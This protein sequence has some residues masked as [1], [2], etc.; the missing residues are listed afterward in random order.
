MLGARLLPAGIFG[1]ASAE[2]EA[3]ARPYAVQQLLPQRRLLAVGRQLERVEARGGGG[4]PRRLLR[5]AEEEM[6]EGETLLLRVI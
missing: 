4:Q 2:L 6:L 1:R 5:R 3:R